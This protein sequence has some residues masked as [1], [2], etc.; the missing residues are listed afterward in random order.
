MA[1]MMAIVLLLGYEASAFSATTSN[2]TNSSAAHCSGST[3]EECLVV[4]Q[5]N[6]GFFSDPETSLTVHYLRVTD[7]SM[8]RFNTLDVR[9]RRARPH[10]PYYL[11]IPNPNYSK[12]LNT[13]NLQR[14]Q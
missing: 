10:Q 4:D 3:M 2:N 8:N 12:K 13:G 14:R 9:C 1:T 7:G 11:C 6:L 5:T